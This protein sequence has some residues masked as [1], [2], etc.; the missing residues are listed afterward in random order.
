MYK[1]QHQ[2]LKN[3]FFAKVFREKIYESVEQLQVDLDA[4]IV[5]YNERRTHSGYRTKGRTPMQ[6]LKDIVK[7]PKQEKAAA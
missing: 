5:F 4:F 1:R 7:Q 2:T 6:T 3:E